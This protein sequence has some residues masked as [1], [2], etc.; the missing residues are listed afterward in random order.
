ML[1]LII[2]EENNPFAKQNLIHLKRIPGAVCCGSKPRWILL[3]AVIFQWN[4]F[5][6]DYAKQEDIVDMTWNI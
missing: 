6:Q 4:L 1:Q 3:G 2:K 5:C